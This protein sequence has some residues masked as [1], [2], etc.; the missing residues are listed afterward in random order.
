MI[1]YLNAMQ[2]NTIMQCIQPHNIVT[3]QDVMQCNADEHNTM[4]YN[5]LLLDVIKSVSAIAYI[6]S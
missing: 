5:A 3:N 4:R 1:G 2:Y 6:T